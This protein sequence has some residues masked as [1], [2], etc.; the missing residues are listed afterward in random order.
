MTKLLRDVRQSLEGGNPLGETMRKFPNE[1]DRLTCALI[2]AGE[3]GGILDSILLR[4]C[5]IGR[6]HV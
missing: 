4:L 1:F 3:Q 6:A 5:E 2:E